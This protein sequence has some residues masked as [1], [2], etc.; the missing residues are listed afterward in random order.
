MVEAKRKPPEQITKDLHPEGV[1]ESQ[2]ESPA[3]LYHLAPR[4]GA[5]V[6]ALT[7]GLRFAATTGYF[8]AALRAASFAF[9]LEFA[10]VN[11][12]LQSSVC[13][14]VSAYCSALNAH[15]SLPIR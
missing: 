10:N 4:R 13:L 7:G 12:E 9:K 8:L 6:P 2:I 14:L 1:H 15:A 5:D 3:S 11:K